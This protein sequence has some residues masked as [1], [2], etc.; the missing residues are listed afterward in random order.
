MGINLLSIFDQ[1]LVVDNII[2]FLLEDDID[3]NR[4]TLCILRFVFKSERAREVIDH[5]FSY[6]AYDARK[7]KEMIY[8]E[9]SSDNLNL[10]ADKAVKQI[11]LIN[12]NKNW[13]KDLDN[14]LHKYIQNNNF[15]TSYY[16]SQVYDIFWAIWLT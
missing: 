11:K 5:H 4:E 15:N 16:H 13:L 7:I 8:T 2:T 3:N 12:K 6:V 14:K 9:I 1:P 10:L